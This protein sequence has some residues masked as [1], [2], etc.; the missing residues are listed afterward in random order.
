MLSELSWSK[1]NKHDTIPCTRGTQSSHVQRRK[2]DD[3]RLSGAAGL[4]RG[5][6]FHADRVSVLQ[7]GKV[8]DLVV[9]A[10]RVTVLDSAELPT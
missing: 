10:Q 7:G 5:L 8:P 6:L 2:V 3:P 9:A 1:D 4:G